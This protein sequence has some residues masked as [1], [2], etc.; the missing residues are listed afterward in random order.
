MC[1]A[2]LAQDEPAWF[3]DMLSATFSPPASSSAAACR[4][5]DIINAVCLCSRSTQS[6]PNVMAA[7]ALSRV[8]ELHMTFSILSAVR[9]KLCT[10][11]AQDSQPKFSKPS[12]HELSESCMRLILEL[13]MSNAHWQQASAAGLMQV[14][15]TQSAGTGVCLQYLNEHQV[16][17]DVFLAFVTRCKSGRQEP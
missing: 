14:Q 3:A 16:G 5:Q 1:K 4:L 12:A 10:C 7:G 6:L 8:T 9:E 11:M 2:I 13:A 15:S 17:S